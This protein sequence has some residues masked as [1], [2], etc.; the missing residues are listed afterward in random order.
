[1]NEHFQ[2]YKQLQNKCYKTDCY[3]Q[4]QDHKCSVVYPCRYNE[5]IKD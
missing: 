5:P 1:M 3:L 4:T 2:E